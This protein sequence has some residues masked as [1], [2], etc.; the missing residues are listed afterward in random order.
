[1]MTLV[2]DIDWSDPGIGI[3][4]LL[5]IV[6]MPFTYSITNGVGAGFVTYTVIAV[7]RGRWRDVHP[8]MY[9]VSA[10]FVWYFVHGMHRL[11]PAEEVA[12]FH[13]GAGPR[14]PA[15]R[16]RA[17]GHRAERVPSVVDA[18]HRSR[19]LLAEQ[20][21]GDPA[22]TRSTGHAARASRF[23]IAAPPDRRNISRSAPARSSSVYGWAPAK[24]TNGTIRVGARPSTAS[25]RAI[26][27]SIVSSEC[28]RRARSA[29]QAS[30]IAAS[31]A[32]L[33]GAPSSATKSQ[34]LVWC[35]AG[36]VHAA[37]TASATASRGT[38]PSPNERI[39][40]RAC[41]AC[42]GDSRNR[43]SSAG[44]T[45]SCAVPSGAVPRE[46]AHHRGGHPLR[47]PHHG[48]AAAAT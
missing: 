48:A 42:S 43:S 11:S 5:T 16:H 26:R 3:P 19:L 29:R 15:L 44:R 36:A 13:R 35:G 31:S 38:G 39:V 23:W 47:L 27:R 40:R 45:R 1:M 7:L 6:M 30:A 41:S 32:R 46:P 9:I 22:A 10:I 34:G 21:R 28:R 17:T 2:K 25:L 8:L 12:Q 33:A 24:R 18:E 14:G 37:A 20:R 4:A